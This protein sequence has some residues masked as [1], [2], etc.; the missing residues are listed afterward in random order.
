MKFTEFQ[1]DTRLRLCANAVFFAVM[2]LTLEAR[3]RVDRLP[4]YNPLH[5]SLYSATN[6]NIRRCV[7][8]ELVLYRLL[9]LRDR[10]YDN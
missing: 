1:D 3:A 7:A 8:M 10:E 5:I 6:R 4:Y 2:C 9:E